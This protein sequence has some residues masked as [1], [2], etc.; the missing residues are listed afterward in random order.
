MR[1]EALRVEAERTKAKEERITEQVI[2]FFFFHVKLV[3]YA[4]AVW[5]RCFAVHARTRIQLILRRHP[6]PHLSPSP[7]TLTFHPHLSPPAAVEGAG[8]GA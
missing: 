8:E 2:V 6:H 5:L 7:F 4:R 1:E 3:W